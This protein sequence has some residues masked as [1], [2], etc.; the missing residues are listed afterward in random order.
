MRMTDERMGRT[1]EV[2]CLI[3]GGTYYKNVCSKGTTYSRER[4]IEGR[5]LVKEIRYPFIEKFEC[6][7][8]GTLFQTVTV[9]YT[10]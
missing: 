1:E 4:L 7:K 8:Y 6:R 9:S 2:G 10:V 3:D 5:S